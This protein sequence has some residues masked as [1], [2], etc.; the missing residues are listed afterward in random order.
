MPGRPW[1]LL[2]TPGAVRQ[3]GVIAP[4]SRLYGSRRR[5][6]TDV[7]F[8]QKEEE[9]MKKRVISLLLALVLAVSLL[10]TAAW[11]ARKTFET[12]FNEVGL[13]ATATNSTNYSGKWKVTTKDGGEVLKSGAL[14]GSTASFTL[15][16]TE[17]THLSFEYKV[18]S[19]SDYNY[20]YLSK[21]GQELTSA[22][23]QFGNNVGWTPYTLDVQKNDILKFGYKKTAD[24]VA[25]ELDDCVYLCNFTCG[26]PVVVTFHANGGT[27]D[28]YTQN[29]YGGK[30]TLKAN[31]FTSSGKV[32]AGWA[33]AEN[34]TV[35]YPDG[36]TIEN[37]TS[38]FDLYAVWGDAYT[39]TFDNGGVRSTADVAQNTALG[40][41]KMPKD[42]TK[43]GY[44]FEGWFNGETKLT[45]DTVIT[46]N[47][48][49]TA[50]WTP[51]RYT[52]KFDRNAADAVGSMDDISAA[53]DEEVK[54]PLC[55]FT[56]DGYTFTG[57]GSYKGEDKVKNLAGKDGAVV[58]LKASWRGLPVNVIA[59][60]NY[61]DAENIVRTGAVGN[62][63]NYI[64][65]TD[66]ETQYSE[67]K[68]PV[69]PGYIFDGWY[70]A[71]EG[72][73]KISPQYKFT[74][75]DAENGKTLYAHWT[76]GITVHFDGNGYKSTIADKTVKPD[77]VFSKLPYLSSYS[78]P[79]NKTLDGWYIKNDDGSFGD[80]VTK[81]IDF[82]SLDEV[83]L[84]A[85]WR[86]YQY[87]IKYNV[88]Y[89]DKSSVT[90]TMAD[91]PA[92]FGQNV[93][94]NKCT[95]TR[96]GYDFAGWAIS[97]Y[98]STVKYKN[99]DIINRQ[100][101][102]WDSEDGEK[103]NLYAVWTQNV[104]GKAMAAIQSKLPTNNVVRTAGDLGLPTSGDG[105]TISYVS[106][107]T[108]LL[109]NSGMVVLPASGSATVTL[110]ATITDTVTSKT[111][112][113]EYILT[114]Y[115]ATTATTEAELNAAVSKLTGNFKPVYGTD[116]NAITAVEKKLL[117]AGCEGIAVS[118][119]EAVTDSG[120]YSG[121]DQDGTIHYYFNPGM[122]KYG[123]YF[124]TTFVLSKN[125]ASVEKKWYTSID[126]DKAKVRE[127]LNTVADTLTVPE[128]ATA[129]MTLPLNANGKGWSKVAWV[130]ND[131]ALKIGQASYYTSTYP[132]TLNAA[133]DTTVVLTATVKCNSVDGVSVTREFACTVLGG[134]ST[135]VD[136]Q[137]KLDNALSAPG[138]RDFVTGKKLT[139]D[140]N[141]VY[142]VCND[143]QFPTTRDLKI[144]G[145]YTPVVITSSDPGVIEAPTTPNSA[146]VWVYRPLPGEAAKTVTLTMKILDR[147]N[148]PQPGDDL[149]TMRVLASKEIKVTV[150]PLTQTEIDA[151][152]ALMERVKVNYWNGIRNANTDQNN[153]TTDLHAFQEC[154]LGTD[155]SL[156]WAYDRKDL[157][158]HGIVPVPLDNWYDQQ[159]WRLFR[160]SNAE[161]ITHENL[162]VSRREESKAVTV[163]S[164]LSSETLGKYAEK[165]PQNADFQ[166]LY[167]QPVTV[168]L[169]VT[170]TQYAQGNNEGRVQAARR[171]L[172]ARPTVTV[173]FSLSGRGMGF[174]E[175][176]LKYAEGSTVYDVFSDLLAEH[177]YTCKRRGSYIA[178]IT[179]NSGITLEEFDEGKNSGWMYRVNGELVGRYM[180]AQGLEDGDR[181]ELYFTSDWTSEP[182]AEGWQKPGKIETIVNADGSVTKIETKSDGTVIETTT[183]RD[184]STL[185]A[186]TSP[187]GRVETVEKRA[188]GTTVETVES[189]SGEIT[190]SVSV[191]KS[192]GS[193]RVDI[194]VSKPTGSMVAVIVHPDG[195]EEIV[196]GSIVT[197]TGVALRAEGDVRLKVIDNA[198]RFNDMANH[199]AK[200]AVEF[201]SSRELFNGVGNDAF[202]PDR[203]MTRGMVS[204]VL[205]RLAGADTAGGETWYAKGTVWAVENGISDGTAPE[206]PVTR[207]QLAAMLYRYAGSPAVSGELGFDDADSI[208][209]WARDAV[210]WC[211]DN[212]ILNG[213]GG[214]RMT[215]Q[216]LARR[217]Q[218][219][220]ML[221]R[222]LQ[223]TV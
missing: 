218:V 51:I 104:F 160:S 77:E 222:F 116:T 27:G 166:K 48:I 98:G 173:S 213:V 143:I 139:A 79:A 192:V 13:P 146:R 162:L 86:D 33:T 25:K 142:A 62:N 81:D 177:G 145:K 101:D 184:G 32:F 190:A 128:T 115:S 141:G 15:T 97:S 149:S 137:A 188:D 134:T 17:D 150:Q 43:K 19:G 161:V 135:G 110:T 18:S 219:A 129:D 121:I 152:I 76:K 156:T 82:S 9:K 208:S 84:I 35:V 41:A 163:T 108:E 189:A 179:S 24:Y 118:I 106:S 169:V 21:N 151:E 198:K 181:I 59:N 126:W 69:R 73:S 109:S 58:T 180:S 211:V 210:R 74:A 186:E 30:G 215:P 158:N 114:L 46:G 147:P 209:A 36:A 159:I 207:E 136:Y 88:M 105:Y 92:A 8:M 176:D 193:T 202:G 3:Q 201:A 182:G 185:T 93:Q 175:S 49:Y 203:S 112:T 94:L 196:K 194:P 153:V 138:L 50:K 214:N 10:P 31:T 7:F 140:E 217:G 91:Q 212:G 123:S 16:F 75:E 52:I 63:Y 67:L 199:W 133:E 174:A 144:D 205:A 216:D 56:R 6:G 53:Y 22:G 191:P 87:I 165:Y 65:K 125:G 103:Y 100:W 54:L 99:G 66:G 148:G 120:N 172:A 28:D 83:T 130:S 132:I 5:A 64:V 195:T 78:Y 44:T 14:N 12:Y 122:T 80:A 29:I 57:W 127:A 20:F 60:L 178:A 34:G 1:T 23:D 72:G 111:Y 96:E 183:W 131:L 37:V 154:Y 38:D 26:T 2:P 124:Y 171:A 206:Q 197:E 90:G 42:P 40:A 204:T 170:G 71:A 70:D 164:Y 68:S 85:K 45:A 113:K 157:K 155:G 117:D 102:N 11:A 107:N 119:K 89:N 4:F 220:A 167:Q 221:M 187:N 95:F 55:A 39:V 223:A 200:D 168:D 47:V 61:S